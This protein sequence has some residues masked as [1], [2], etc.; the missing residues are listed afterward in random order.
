MRKKKT[1]KI[2]TNFVT[3]TYCIFQVNSQS[4]FE[5]ILILW[6]HILNTSRKSFLWYLQR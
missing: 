4:A 1:E 2:E 6:C 5:S 3:K